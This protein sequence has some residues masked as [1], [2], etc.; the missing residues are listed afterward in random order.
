[1]LLYWL[2]LLVV[3]C[4]LLGGKV[5]NLAFDRLKIRAVWLLPLVCLSQIA[6]IVIARQ[7]SQVVSSI[8]LIAGY[9][10]LLVAAWLNR[11]LS[12]LSVVLVGI[13]LNFLVITA[14]GGVMPTTLQTIETTGRVQNLTTSLSANPAINPL[15]GSKAGL[16]VEPKLILLGD[17][18][19]VPLPGRLASALSV[20]DLIIAVG[21]TYFCYK[22]M[23]VPIFRRRYN[24]PD[25]AD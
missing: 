13:C 16:V 5:S 7:F 9:S 15:S 21:L 12:G 19:A 14:N 25:Y 10:L 18:I 1:M 4:K 11:H 2:P 8:L 24:L 20:G 23:Q 22:T 6:A 3:I 17:I